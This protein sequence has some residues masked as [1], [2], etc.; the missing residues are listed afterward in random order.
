MDSL[1]PSPT[2]NA[3][4]ITVLPLYLLH[5][6]MVYISRFGLPDRVRSDH[7]GE[8]IDVWRCML[9]SHNVDPMCI[10]TC[11]STHNERI[12]RLWRDVH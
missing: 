8:N 10:V 4:L 7:G 1:V 9:D 3:L 12:E 5:F 11:S 6:E 2:F